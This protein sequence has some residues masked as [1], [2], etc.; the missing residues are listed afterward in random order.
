MYWPKICQTLTRISAVIAVQRLANTSYGSSITPRSRSSA[1]SAPLDGLSRNVKMMPAR[2]TG[3][4]IGTK[5]TVRSSRLPHIHR[6]V[7]TIANSSASGSLITVLPTAKI[8][9][10]TTAFQN[11]PSAAI[12]E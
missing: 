1:F 9:V 4:M 7:R 12:A 10:L 11:R 6:R 3:M 8:R 5:N 2:A